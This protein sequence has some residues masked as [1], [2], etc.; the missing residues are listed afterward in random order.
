[1][2]RGYRLVE[3]K[4]KELQWIIYALYERICNVYNKDYR[5]KL[6]EL[7]ERLIRILKYR[8]N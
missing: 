3:L 6:E 1:M 2:K 5:E 7:S 4:T 8:K